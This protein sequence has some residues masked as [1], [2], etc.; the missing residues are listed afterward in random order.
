M[1]R[2]SAILAPSGRPYLVDSLEDPRM[3]LDDPRT[4]DAVTGGSRT[5]AGVRVDAQTAIGQPAIWRAINLLA[6]D[7]AKL[8]LTPYVRQADN[9][10]T[11]AT[12]HPGYRLTRRKANPMMTAF[13]F[14][15][16]M[17]YHA[18]FQGNACAVIDRDPYGLPQ[19]LLLLDPAETARAVIGGRGYFVTTINGTQIKIPDN[20]VLHIMGLS[21]D[22]LWGHDLMEVFAEA[23][24]LTVAA[25]RFGARF[26]GHGTNA[27]GVLMVPGHFSEEKIRNTFAAWDEMN[28]GL[29]NSHKVALLQDGVKW[30]QLTIAPEQAQFLGTRQFEIR[31]IANVF[32]IPPHKLGDNSATSYNS[33]EQENANYLDESLD[34][35]LVQTEHQYNHKLLSEEEQQADSHFFEFNRN[36]RLRMDA[37]TRAEV[38]TKFFGLGMSPNDF[39]RREN[40]PTIGPVGDQRFRPGNF[41]P[42]DAP[43]PAAANPQARAALKACIVDRLDRLQRIE[44]KRELTAKFYEG[45]SPQILE[46]LLPV[47]S[48]AWAVLAPNLSPQQTL[49]AYVASYLAAR[50]PQIDSG[51]QAFDLE[52]LAES[53]LPLESGK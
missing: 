28:A 1:P 5:E 6:N 38:Y 29:S 30:Q 37:A 50:Q 46:A 8:P 47:V 3:S 21:H 25:R 34:P 52:P 18:V 40:M 45:F 39:F 23:F 35:W 43:A 9:G 36:A 33:L 14:L 12:D 32:G 11:P 22:G 31:E 7:V 15:R 20:D 13:I 4:W 44:A 19:D 17:I 16:T 24:G 48:A 2:E 26:F 51:Y 49:E 27:S 42:L 41:V 10:K 53:L